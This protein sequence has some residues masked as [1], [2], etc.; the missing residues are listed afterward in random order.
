MLLG[1]KRADNVKGA[2]VYGRHDPC[3]SAHHLARRAGRD[4]LGRSYLVQ[5]SPRRHRAGLVISASAHESCW[6]RRLRR[7]TP[8][9]SCWGRR[10]SSGGAVA[11]RR[12]V[13]AGLADLVLE[14]RSARALALGGAELRAGGG[15]GRARQGLDRDGVQAQGRAGRARRGRAGQAPPS[16]RAHVRA[17]ERGRQARAWPPS[18]SAITSL[19]AHAVEH[20]RGLAVHRLVRHGVGHHAGVLAHRRGEERFAAGRGARH[21]RSA[22]R[23]GGRSG[24]GHPRDHRLQ[25]RRQ[26]HRRPARGG[27]RLGRGVGRGA[28]RKTRRRARTPCL[29]RRRRMAISVGRGAAVVSATSTSRRWS[30]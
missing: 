8:S 19:D 9:S 28:G 2:I 25:L 1:Q 14:D 15:D 18:S 27:H 30:T 6:L 12:R 20:R 3:Q 21:R 23:H 24:R 11:A 17:A 22:D 13:G 29:R 4:G 16:A 26:A 5:R 10:A 7:S